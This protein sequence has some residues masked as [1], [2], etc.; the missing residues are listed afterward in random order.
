MNFL[1]GG[2]GGGQQ[3]KSKQYTLE[4]LRRMYTTLSL[5][6]KG[7]LL[8]TQEQQVIENIRVVAEVVVYAD[9]HTE[10]LFDYFC[11]LNMLR[12]FTNVLNH[13]L[14]STSIKVQLLQSVSILVQNIRSETAL[15]YTLSNNHVNQFISHPYDFSNEELLA[16]YISFL[17]L[18]SLKLNLNTIQFFF[19]SGLKSFPLYEEAIKFYDNEDAMV[20]TAVKSVTLSVY[21]VQDQAVR[22]FVLHGPPH[23][24]F[25]QVSQHI[26]KRV[27]YLHLQLVRLSTLNQ[28][29]SNDKDTISS[30]GSKENDEMN[31]E[32]GS[33]EYRQVY[34]KLE[35]GL[36]ENQDHLLYL[37]DVIQMGVPELERTIAETSTAYLFL[38]LLVTSLIPSTNPFSEIEDFENEELA[39]I[40]L[41]Y[42][43]ARKYLERS[44]ITPPMLSL[45][46]LAQLFFALNS[47]DLINRLVENIFGPSLDDLRLNHISQ[48]CDWDEKAEGEFLEENPEADS[49]DTGEIRGESE[50][51]ESI[52]TDGAD[53]FFCERDQELMGQLGKSRSVFMSYLAHSDDRLCL[54]ACICI[55]A[56][57]QN[58]SANKDKLVEFGIGTSYSGSAIV[59]E[60][61]PG[62]NHA[63]RRPKLPPVKKETVRQSELTDNFLARTDDQDNEEDLNWF[64]DD[65]DG[66]LS[67]NDKSISEKAVNDV[68]DE[69][70]EALATEIISNVLENLATGNDNY[71]KKDATTS[72]VNVIDDKDVDVNV[73]DDDDVTDHV[74]GNEGVLVEAH[75]PHD[76][77]EILLDLLLRDP[78][79][80]PLTQRTVAKLLID[81]TFTENGRGPCLMPNHG[82]TLTRAYLKSVERVKV[83]LVMMQD[84]EE[85]FLQA[86]EGEWRRLRQGPLVVS[87]LCSAPGIL[88]PQPMSS[89]SSGNGAGEGKDVGH[90]VLKEL[91]SNVALEWR[92]PQTQQ[93]DLSTSIRS[94]MVM[95][96]LWCTL[97]RKS[98]AAFASVSGND[99]EIKEG[100][101]IDLE[102]CE[103]VKVGES[104]RMR[105]RD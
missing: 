18:L 92:N 5:Y 82:T 97:N 48:A 81:L 91:L 98:N 36:A 79:C 40:G 88:L 12:L 80:R 55:Y 71:T 72:D 69:I 6:L 90:A 49:V 38:P 10:L 74:D 23:G 9:Q 11:E 29:T 39:K 65:G 46:L 42:S 99:C 32:W 31:V 35:N 104:H 61:E 8:S 1:F 68:R 70:A 53:D 25:E 87:Q 21:A 67:K 103:Y 13:P 52:V 66:K 14:C 45:L 93:E 44:Q 27:R 54:V 51:R 16:Y 78:P 83:H 4:D 101:R 50:D 100:R 63:V 2:V 57:L 76:L 24:H 19:N 37:H 96:L 56:V 86:F 95:T 7:N 26:H 15:Y 41:S 22:N 28:E 20:R 84:C 64:E 62:F 17:K 73:D 77:V 105:R 34:Q 33:S 30:D 59:A 89:V 43:S 94:F 3:R 47:E 102:N 75:Y 58:E 85:E 60:K